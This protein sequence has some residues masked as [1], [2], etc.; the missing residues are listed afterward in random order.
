VFSRFDDKTVVVIGAGKMG[1]VT[2]RHL[3][4]LAPKRIIVTNRSPEKAETVAKGC[5]GYTVPWEQL[6]DA[7][8]RADI[9]LS[10]TGAPEPIVTRER[11]DRVLTRRAKEMA[12]I[13][14][15][16]VPRD[17]DPRIHDGEAAFLYNIDDLKAIGERTLQDRLKHIAPA[18]AI[19]EQEQKRFL[20]EWERR[21]N[22]PVI[23]QL[24]QMY[25]AKRQAILKEMFD[26]LNGRLEPGDRAIIEG[27]FRLFQNQVLHGPISALAEDSHESGRHTLLEA[28]RKLFRLEE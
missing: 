11:W 21:R 18:E 10:T 13:F 5:G 22:G 23:A 3:K 28:L 1:E 16:A 12:V 8:V 6:D 2:L 7:L 24:V 14:D 15:I 26:R 9:I 27:G 25:E 20:K 4:L 17:F 19:V